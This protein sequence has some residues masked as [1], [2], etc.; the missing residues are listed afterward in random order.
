MRVLLSVPPCQFRSGH[1]VVVILLLELRV[2]PTA[3]QGIVIWWSLPAVY[4]FLRGPK[5]QAFRVFRGKSWKVWKTFL[6]A[7]DVGLEGLLTGSTVALRIRE[8][9][10][11]R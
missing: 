4:D 10:G 6:E 7:A 5:H 9:D 11:L 3:L 8:D 2:R 1:V